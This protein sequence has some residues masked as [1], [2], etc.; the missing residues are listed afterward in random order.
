MTANFLIILP[1]RRNFINFDGNPNEI[2]HKA[3]AELIMSKLEL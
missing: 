2:G 1:K 3:I